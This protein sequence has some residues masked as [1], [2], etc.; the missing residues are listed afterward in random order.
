MSDATG[1]ERIPEQPYEGFKGVLLHVSSLWVEG[2]AF[3][4]FI[5]SRRRS[6]GKVFLNHERIHLRQQLEMGLILFYIWYFA[7]YFF[8]LI[9]YRDHALA[10]YNISFEREAYRNECDQQYLAKRGIW[11]FFYYL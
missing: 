1:Q 9:Q 7:E 6:P 4:P 2:L 10:Y 8:R 5:L 3:F 11:R